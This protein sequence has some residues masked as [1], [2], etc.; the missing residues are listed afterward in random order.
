MPTKDYQTDLLKESDGNSLM[1]FRL[2][3]ESRVS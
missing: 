1:P 2:G 3:D